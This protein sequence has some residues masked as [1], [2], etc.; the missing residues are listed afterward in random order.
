MFGGL[1]DVES[2]GVAIFV[3]VE[4]NAVFDFPGV[5]A[6]AVGECDVEAVGFG[7]VFDLHGLNLLSGKAL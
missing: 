3:D 5:R 7:E 1:V 2:N 6:G 4:D